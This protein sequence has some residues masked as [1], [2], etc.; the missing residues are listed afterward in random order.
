MEQEHDSH[1]IELIG[2]FSAGL[3]LIEVSLGSLLHSFHV[4]LA[5][6]F[7]SLNQGFLLCR[8][9]VRSRAAGLGRVGYSISNVAAVLKSLSPAGKKL[10]PM[11]SLSAQGLLFSLGELLLGASLAGWMLGMFLLSLWTALQQIATYY[12]FFGPELIKALNFFL[13]KSFHAHGLGWRQIFWVC[14]AFVGAKALLGVSLA[15]VAWRGGGD[16]ALQDRLLHLA[17]MK[18][19]QSA[20]APRGSSL[21]L[22]LRDLCRPLFLASL[23]V[24]LF[25]LCFSER[26]IAGWIWILMRPIAVGFLFF[27]LA[28][29]LTLDRW[30]LKLNGTRGEEFAKACERAL[31]ELRQLARKK[32][33][34]RP[35][36]LPITMKA[37]L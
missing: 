35:L 19:A 13:E 32:S 27:Y 37:K 36:A 28:H 26:N 14:G 15:W 18:S 7:L 6:D 5:G 24:T 34:H 21:W 8:A 17:D 4:P 31:V 9:S 1:R 11:L 2:K 23:A 29:T 25:F 20:E 33:T 22:A 10:G 3:S 12:L 16:S 30:L